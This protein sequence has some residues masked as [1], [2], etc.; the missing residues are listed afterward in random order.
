MYSCIQTL[1]VKHAKRQNYVMILHIYEPEVKI[2]R[3]APPKNDLIVVCLMFWSR[4][5]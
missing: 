5:P 3:S 2:E 1:Y 4:R